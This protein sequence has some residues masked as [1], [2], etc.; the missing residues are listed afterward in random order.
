MFRERQFEIIKKTRCINV[1]LLNAHT[2]IK[3]RGEKNAKLSPKW[4]G[5]SFGT[6]PNKASKEEESWVIPEPRAGT[7]GAKM[8]GRP[9]KIR[10]F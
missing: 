2:L 9:R 4:S 1:I 5:K 7:R 10:K 6:A 8:G 3:I